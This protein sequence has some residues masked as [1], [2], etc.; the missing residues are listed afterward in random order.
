VIANISH[1]WRMTRE[2]DVQGLRER[3]ET[4]VSVRVLGTNFALAQRVARLIEPDPMDTEISAG[5]LGE[6]RPRADVLVAVVSGALTQDAARALRD[7]S[8]GEAPLVVIQID[9]GEAN[10]LVLG[11][12]E[13]R[14]V[15]FEPTLPDDRAR[16]RLFGALVRA[17]PDEMLTLGR[18][19]PLLRGPIAEQLIRDTSRVNAQFAAVSSLPANIPLLGGLVGEVADILVLTKNQV[20]LLFKLAGLYGRDLELGRELILEVLPVVGGAFFWRTTARTL[21]GLIPGLFGMVPKVVVAYMGTFV[22]GGMARYYFQHGRRPPDEL[23]SELRQ[24][25]TRLAH[26]AMHRLRPGSSSD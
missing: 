22:V 19:H 4:P 8:V 14:I 21:V 26:E 15:T 23:V 20:L 24:D 10:L 9:D 2:L 16:E 11:L 6:G 3:F 25:A 18:R 7:L 5:L 1:F 12:A 13:E 17:A